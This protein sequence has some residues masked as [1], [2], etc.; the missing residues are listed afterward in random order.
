MKA[1]ATC[2]AA[3]ILACLAFSCAPRS[4]VAEAKAAAQGPTRPNPSLSTAILRAGQASILAEIA[5]SAAERETGL[6]FRKELAEG[7]GMLFVFE[8][9]Q[10]LSFWMKNT[11]LPLSIAYLSSD[12]TIRDIL[13]LEPFSLAPVSSSRSVRYALEAPRG[14]FERAG[15]KVGDRFELPALP[16]PGQ[17]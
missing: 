8:V 3:L 16:P 1:P 12:G 7:K 14:W 5:D 11:S 2:L 13:P 4:A 17:P 10:V 15:L 6:M 9:D